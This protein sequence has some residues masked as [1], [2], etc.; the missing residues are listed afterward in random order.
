MALNVILVCLVAVT[1]L[2]V[3]LIVDLYNRSAR[4]AEFAQ[5][6]HEA[7]LLRRSTP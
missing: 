7:N 5:E 3:L 2:N 1:A 6:V 4:L